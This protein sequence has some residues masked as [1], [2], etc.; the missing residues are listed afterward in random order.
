MKINIKKFL[1]KLL[2]KNKAKSK[3]RILQ[4]KGKPG[5]KMIKRARRHNLDG[6]NQTSLIT[7]T[8]NQIKKDKAE[9]ARLNK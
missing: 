2:R 5:S 8:F 1:K 3:R 9:V 7:R 6:T 4:F